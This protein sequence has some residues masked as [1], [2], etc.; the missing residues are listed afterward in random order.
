MRET[1]ANNEAEAFVLYH[2]FLAKSAL[3]LFFNVFL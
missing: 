3:T 2:F 1:T